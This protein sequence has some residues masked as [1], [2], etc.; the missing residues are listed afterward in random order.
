MPAIGFEPAI[1]ASERPQIHVLGRAATSIGRD[2]HMAQKSRNHLKI[3]GARS[4]AWSKFH[5]EG[6]QILGATVKNLVA[7]ATWWPAVC[8]PLFWDCVA[9]KTWEREVFWDSVATK[10]LEREVFWDSVATKTL[11]QAMFLDSVATK[12]W[13]PEVFS[14]SVATNTWEPEVLWDSVATKT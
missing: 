9:T 8:A 3:L 1:P 2:A 11:E 13:E 12:T 4:V 14:D 5:T 6:P 7:R 10:T